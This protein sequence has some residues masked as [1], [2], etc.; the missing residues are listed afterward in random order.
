MRTT[1]CLGFAGRGSANPHSSRSWARVRLDFERAL[2]RSLPVLTLALAFLPAPALAQWRPDGVGICTDA[3]DQHGQSIA[4]DV[5]GGVIVTWMDHRN[6]NYDIYAQRLDSTGTARWTTNGVALCTATG[7][8]V[9]PSIVTDGA[10]GAIATWS[11][12]RNGNYDIYAQRISA[13]GVVQWAT[14]GVALCTA[15]GDQGGATIVTDGAG[16]AIVTWAD[17]RNG[18][19]DIYARRILAG[20][21]VQWTVDGVALSA[22]TGDQYS[23]AIV[24]DGVGGAIV[25]WSDWNSGNPD[26]YAQRVNAA[27][28]V[29]WGANGVTLCIA[30]GDQSFPAIASNGASGAIVTWV[31]RRNGNP[32]IYAR[33]VNA[34]GSAQWGPDGVALCTNTGSQAE[35]RIVA[36]G[37]G[38]AIVAWSDARSDADDIYAQRI[39]DSGV[40]QWTSNGVAVCTATGGQDYPGIAS[41]SAGGAIVVWEDTRNGPGDIYAQ[42]VNVTGG[43]QWSVNGEAIGTATGNQFYPAIASDGVGGAIAVWDDSRGGNH[44]VYAQHTPFRIVASHGLHGSTAP[45]ST[46]LVGPV[47]TTFV[48]AGADASYGIDPAT[49]Y[50]VSDV[51][52]DS[53]AIGP[54]SSYTFPAVVQNHTLHAYFDNSTMSDTVATSAR[55]Y[56]SFAFDIVP[57]APADSVKSVLDELWPPDDT[58]WR[59]AHWDPA[60]G[61]GGGYVFAN[62]GLEAVAAGLGYWLITSEAKPVEWQGKPL[63]AGPYTL[64]LSN[65]AGWQQIGNPFR[66]PI[67]DTALWVMSG[68]EHDQLTDPVNN[69]LTDHQ[70]YEAGYTTP[71]AHTLQP[72]RAYWLHKTV[73]GEVT[74]LFPER[75]STGAAA[76]PAMAKP[77]GAL[78]AL[79]IVVRQADRECGPVLVGAVRSPVRSGNALNRLAAPGPPEAA[80]RMTLAGDE[81]SGEYAWSFKPEASQMSWDLRLQGAVAPGEM[82]LALTPFDLPSGTRVWLSEPTTGWTREVT[83][84]GSVSLAAFAG[85]RTLR[86]TVA[87]AA[88]VPPASSPGRQAWSAY[89]NPFTGTAG[90]VFSLGA[91]GGAAVEIFDVQGRSVRRLER[92]GLGAG[93]HV[94]V[95][96]GRDEA[97]RVVRPGVYLARCRSGEA[98][99]AVRLV[100]VE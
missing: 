3:G 43:V 33:R 17:Y 24:S 86:L 56:A 76:E 38:G 100:R 66:Y 58:R 90:L 7:D 26:V 82:A 2:R 16:G 32:D 69:T 75:T 1:I 61:A 19:D 15:T 18:N 94:M 52:V 6:G 88:G 78:W 71:V 14:N 57:P 54:V 74:L 84:N 64:A 53:R 27:G 10:G 60:S 65:L 47:D 35:P 68:A 77:E 28:A 62:T 49:G 79:G 97:G 13:S 41:D 22:A 55:S 67:A 96:D 95:W 91:P 40:S 85:E 72:G 44:D 34:S 73:G 42:R 36:D 98:P 21:T 89:P 25:A 81:R 9:S 45:D 39:N 59:L 4:S 11:D 87:D 12:Y 20:G 51:S 31:D 46:V 92:P 80:V 5:A 99:C 63:S 70:V 93:E 23:P 30:G 8:Q 50:Y 83:G 29:Q 37:T 48:L